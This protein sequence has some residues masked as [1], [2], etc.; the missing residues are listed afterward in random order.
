MRHVR[1]WKWFI[2]RSSHAVRYFIPD[3]RPYALCGRTTDALVTIY[4][5]MPEGKSCETCLRIVVG[6]TEGA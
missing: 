3:G 5:T 4:R 6:A 1:D 2:I